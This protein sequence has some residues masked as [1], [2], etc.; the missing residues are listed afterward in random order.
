MPVGTVPT[1]P[2]FEPVWVRPPVK[3]SPPYLRWALFRGET[4]KGIR[5]ALCE[6]DGDPHWHRLHL[7]EYPTVAELIAEMT[8]ILG[9]PIADTLADVVIEA[10]P[11]AIAH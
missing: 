5:W 6:G 9:R 10:L 11:E 2:E 8:P 3:L 4:L 1:V 7:A